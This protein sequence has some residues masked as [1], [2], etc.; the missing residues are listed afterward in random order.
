MSSAN[1]IDQATANNGISFGEQVYRWVTRRAIITQPLRIRVWTE[2]NWA[3]PLQLALLRLLLAW[4]PQ[5]RPQLPQLPQLRLQPLGLGLGNVQHLRCRFWCQHWN[6]FSTELNNCCYLLLTF[7]AAS[8]VEPGLG[9]KL[10]PPGTKANKRYTNPNS[11]WKAWQAWQ[12]Q[13]A[14]QRKQSFQSEP[15]HLLTACK[16]KILKAVS[17]CLEHEFY[18]ACNAAGWSSPA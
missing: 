2:Q 11:P 8:S 16:C 3:A 15:W 4:T 12:E 9:H 14:W 7:C 5:Q 1:W 6:G 10:K 18:Q 17:K 13:Q